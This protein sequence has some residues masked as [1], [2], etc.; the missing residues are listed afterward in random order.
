L[1][2]YVVGVYYSCLVDL[3]TGRVPDFTRFVCAV[4]GVLSQLNL[5]IGES[6]KSVR[7]GRMLD[8][9]HVGHQ[10]CHSSYIDGV[11]VPLCFT[12][13]VDMCY[14]LVQQLAN[15]EMLWPTYVYPKFELSCFGGNYRVPENVVQAHLDDLVQ[16]ASRSPDIA[17][18]LIEFRD[19]LN[20]C[21]LDIPKRY[22]A[23]VSGVLFVSGRNPT[24]VEATGVS[25][26]G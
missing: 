12:V 22:Q 4:T 16:Y 6:S 8:L 11:E 1:W 17:R 14:S 21:N 15:L 18:R 10:H 3:L 20:H 26:R 2:K 19:F 23:L 5:Y 9:Y 7:L 25:S 13:S 24:P